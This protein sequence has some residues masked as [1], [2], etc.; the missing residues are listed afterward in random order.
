MSP[1]ILLRFTEKGMERKMGEKD[2]EIIFKS[3]IKRGDREREREKKKRERET[4]TQTHKNVCVCV[5]VEKCV[6]VFL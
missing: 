5:F 3:E 4:H 2:G 6:C 1:C